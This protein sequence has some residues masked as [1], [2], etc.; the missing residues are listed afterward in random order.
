[1]HV[2]D[3]GKPER[4]GLVKVLQRSERAAVEQIGFEV[5][6]GPFYFAFIEKRALQTVAMVERKFLPSR[7]LFIL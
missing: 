5:G 2:G 1:V 7:T 6:K 3:F 4:G